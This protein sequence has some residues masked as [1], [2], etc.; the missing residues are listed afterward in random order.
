MR[1]TKARAPC[2]LCSQEEEKLSIDATLWFLL[3]LLFPKSKHYVRFS[4]YL[5]RKCMFLFNV[6]CLKSGISFPHYIP[7]NTSTWK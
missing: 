2:S 6:G 7:Q 3:G 1:A 5:S 4:I